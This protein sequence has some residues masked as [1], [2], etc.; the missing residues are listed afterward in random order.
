MPKPNS[1]ATE[2]FYYPESIRRV[3]APQLSELAGNAE[4]ACMSPMRQSACGST[5]SSGGLRQ[6]EIAHRHV[7]LSRI[8]TRFL[9][10]LSAQMLRICREGALVPALH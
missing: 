8:T 9:G 4:A 3:I 6:A 7:A 1:L 2:Q 10:L 5:P